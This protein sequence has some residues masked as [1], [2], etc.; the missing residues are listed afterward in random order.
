M[1]AL[2][3]RVGADQSEGGGYFNGPVD[4]RTREFAYIP[5]PESATIRSGM[6]KPYSSLSHS[7]KPFEVSLPNTLADGIMH[8]DPD[9]GQ[10]TYGDQGQRARQIQDKLS[11]DDLIVFYAGLLDIRPSSRLVYAIIG[12]YVIDEIVAAT[13][14]PSLKWDENAH[15]RRV[16][17]SGANDIVVRARPGVSGRLERC[18]PIGSFRAPTAQPDKRPSYRVEP[19]MLST[20]GG[21]SIADGFL[22]RSARLPQFI[23]A[24]RFYAW[25]L[26]QKP[27]FIT[28]NN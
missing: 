26:N 8:L 11:T 7:L 9:F 14:V 24:A 18:L 25:F 6:A 27:S 20:W 4:S 28:G 15:T 3:V 5:I 12:L 2:L 17:A 21:L 1:N 19:S 23:E 22:Q 13:S 10:L 16:L